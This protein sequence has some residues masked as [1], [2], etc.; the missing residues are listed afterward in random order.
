MRDAKPG[1]VYLKDYR[2]PAY[3]INRTELHFDLREDCAIVDSRLHLLRDDSV[4]Q[5]VSL[6]LHGQE[7]ELLSV[8]VDGCELTAAEYLRQCRFAA[9]PCGAGT[10]RRRVPDTHPSPGQYF[11]VRARISRAGCFVPSVRRRAF[12]KSLTTSTGPTLCRYSP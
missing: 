1:T 4:A 5:N 3:L 11:T 2:P 7:L 9:Y 12:V 6:E 10:V 8:A